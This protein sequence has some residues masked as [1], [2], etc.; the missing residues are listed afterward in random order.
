MST[1]TL[2]PTLSMKN[3]RLKQPKHHQKSKP[4]GKK[5]DNSSDLPRMGTPW[6]IYIVFFLALTTTII[7]YMQFVRINIPRE[8]VGTWEVKSQQVPEGSRLEIQRNGFFRLTVPGEE[9]VVEG[10]VEGNANVLHFITPNPYNQQ[11]D[12]KIHKIKHQTETEIDLE[13]SQGR[14]MKLIRVD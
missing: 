11:K 10:R 9:N 1:V 7:L 2:L 3:R 8:F 4:Q 13:D 12:T 14:T 5:T 6:L